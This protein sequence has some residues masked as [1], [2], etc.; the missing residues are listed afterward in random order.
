[1]SNIADSIVKNIADNLK[2]T[3]AEKREKLREKRKRSPQGAT[4]AGE[5]QRLKTAKYYAKKKKIKK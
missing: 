5:I 1:M 2:S 3:K 4:L